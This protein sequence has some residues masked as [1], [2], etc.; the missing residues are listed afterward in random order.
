MSIELESI[1]CDLCCSNNSTLL[2]QT[3][4]YRYG[5]PEKFN[6]VKCDRCGLIYINPRPSSK[7]ISKLYEADYTP[8]DKSLIL[9]QIETQKIKRILRKI[10]HRINGQYYD[11]VIAKAEG[12]IL[13]IGCGNGHLLL[14]LKQKCC[15]VYG[16][17]T[18][19]KSV[20]VCNE[21][22]LSVFC[23]TLEE[24]NFTDEFFDMIIMSQVIEHLSSPRNS[25]KEIRRILKPGGRLYI[26]CPNAGSYLTKFFGKYWH[27]WHIPFHFY[28]FTEDTIRNLAHKV[29]FRVEK[30]SAITPDH[31]FTVSLKSYL[32]GDKEKDTRPIE[33][34]KFLDSLFFRVCISLF[35][36]L[37]DFVLRRE[38]DCLKVEVSKMVMLDDEI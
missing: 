36:R 14:S 11:E 12:R 27:G 28:A 35:F 8:E 26:F 15:E 19:P 32:W 21:L 25:L 13:D 2:L 16:V 37:F 33:R 17:E 4:D 1:S 34:G 23:G 5:H 7:S 29:G 18:N 10:W 9:P 38:G 20:K 6:I 3:R 31:F 24:A 30:M 22:G